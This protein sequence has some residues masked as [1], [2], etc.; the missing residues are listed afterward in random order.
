MADLTTTNLLLTKPEVGASTDTWGN[1]VN[2]DLDLVDAVF[3]AAGTGTSVGLNIGTGK[4]LNLAGTVKF[5]GST[6]GTTTVAATAVAGTTVLTLPAATDTLVG[7]ATTDTL[8]NKTLTGAAMNGTVGATTPDTGSFTSLSD[9]G[10]LTFTGTG[11][12]ITGDFTNATVANRVAFQTS[13]TNAN[14]NIFAI[15]NGTGVASGWNALNNP[16]PTNASYIRI[17]VNSTSYTALE[18][19]ILGTGTYLPMTFYTGGSER[20]R[21][22]TSGNVL[23]TSAAGLGYGT[24]SGG[25]VTQATSKSTTVTLNKPTGQITMNNAALLPT[26]SVQFNLSNSLLAA[27]DTLIVNVNLSGVA[28]AGAYSVRPCIS[29]GTAQITLVNES[30]A[31]L[32]EAV[33]LNFAIIKGST[34]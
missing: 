3:A 10:N 4:T 23:V 27:T 28:T 6:S 18:S 29:A 11:N 9:S 17:I 26:A 14:T 32:S 24:G 1:K 25:T 5:V 34:S 7:K 12:R 31:S 33:I 16:D 2:T 22:D 8:T 30:G 20:M 21:V 19:G 13:T 15:P